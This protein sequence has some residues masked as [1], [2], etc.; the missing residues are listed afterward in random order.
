MRQVAV[1]VR[2]AQLTIEI[3]SPE[4]YYNRELSWLAFVRRVISLA[5]GS[6]LPL[7]ERVKFAGIAG[8]LHNE[9]FMKRMS[10]LKRQIAKGS[11]KLSLDGRQPREEF[12]ACREELLDQVEALGRTLETE[13][14]PAL[15]AAGVPILN[16]ADLTPKQ[17]KA[18]EAYFRDSVMPILT[19]LAVDSE[20][21]F[22]F[23]S[24][25]GL[26]LGT[27]MS[28]EGEE[29]R[30]LRIKAP[31]NRPRWVPVPGGVGFVPLEQ[32]IAENLDLM[33]PGT[34]LGP[35]H[36]FRITR[37][38]EGEPNR[39]AA[40]GDDE[41]PAPGSIV[42][43][44]SSELTARRFAGVV[45]LQIGRDAPKSFRKWLTKQ[46]GVTAADVYAVD[47]LIGLSDLLT[48]D[49]PHRDGLFLP[50]HE[51]MTH[52]RL[53]HLPDE[54]QAIFQEIDR[55]DILLHHPY[56]SFDSSVLRFIQS[57]AADPAVLAIKL[58]IYRTS[59]N[60]PIVKALVD[61]ARR[62]IQVAVLIEITARFDEAPNIAVGRYLEN[63]GVH[64]SYGVERLKT[65]VK[66]CLIV[67]EEGQQL[68][69]YAHTG[70]GN[71]HTG[72]ARIYE[73]IGVLTSNRGICEDVSMVFN[74]LTG[75]TPH[76]EYEHLL[77][78]P[79]NM[80]ERFT[81][82]IRRES[83]HAQ[84]GRSAGIEAKMNQLQDP[85]VIREL[86]R[87]SRA[88]VPIALNIRGLCCLRP[89]VSGLS[90]TIRVFS[91]VDRFLEHSR[92]YRFV[93]GGAPEY[94]IGSADWMKRNLNKRVET[95][96]PIRD[97]A[98]KQTLDAILDV[99]R[100]DNSSAWDCGPD[101]V[102]VRR[103]P[104]QGEAPIAAQDTFIQRALQTP[105]GSAPG[106]P[107]KPPPARLRDVGA[108]V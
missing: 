60:S 24:N 66:L 59:A 54:P 108:G 43:Q 58:T 96:V 11:V 9:F 80:R 104:G 89:G 46:I 65:H 41:V 82:L 90:E 34:S 91:I 74:A 29:K 31:N 4:A 49:V 37:G 25:L 45:R 1:G 33:F 63:E 53:R 3:D 40:L 101:C 93:N 48:L 77:V 85:E 79:A 61:A 2:G 94:F 105:A 98:A 22:P 92:V 23:I 69:R 71:Y 87:A 15:A 36:V 39:A 75:A 51:P 67:R 16:Y 6:D 14:R 7:M 64:V 20:H 44:V 17:K 55:G 81:E 5:E 102:Y 38:A 107:P 50:R 106:W 95:V 13:L 73:D 97:D 72:T 76:G 83:E 28:D 70:T 62:A 12:D 18:L 47:S 8:M 35:I 99:Y 26:N 68:R 100:R 84:A 78:A 19:P 27:F 103:R 30:F 56:D 10:G 42:Q 57:A 88:G 52:P 21:P 32:V 86:Y